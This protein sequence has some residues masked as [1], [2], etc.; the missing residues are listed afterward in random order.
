[1]AILLGELVQ[2]PIQ[3]NSLQEW[4]GLKMKL[5]DWIT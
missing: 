1:M 2:E 3:R 5:E 4:K